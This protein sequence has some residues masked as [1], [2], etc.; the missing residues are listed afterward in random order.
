[1][2]GADEL[3]EADVLASAGDPWLPPGPPAMLEPGLAP[4]GIPG[5]CASPG[6]VAEPS[7]V[8]APEVPALL[9]VVAAPA[10]PAASPLPE[11]P[12]LPGVPA[13]SP[14]FPVLAEPVLPVPWLEPEV[15]AEATGSGAVAA[16]EPASG[17]V[18][19]PD[20][21]AGEPEADVAGVGA[22]P[23][24]AGAVVAGGALA[25]ADGDPAGA[26]RL[27][28]V[29]LAV[30]RLVAFARL[31]G[32]DWVA[33]WGW[34]LALAAGEAEAGLDPVA[35]DAAGAG[36]LDAAEASYRYRLYLRIRSIS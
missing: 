29:A 32:W 25:R 15:L 18:D 8:A 19:A 13:V 26:T 10:S 34:D 28:D 35:P 7:E 31:A 24:A 5:I 4:A 16:G 14:V 21:P 11:L 12:A 3:T 22:V 2:T 20:D 36:L 23:A 6:E 33:P 27:G 1:V 9:G 17:A 30:G